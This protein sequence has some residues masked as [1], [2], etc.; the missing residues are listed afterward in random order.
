MVRGTTCRCRCGTDWLTTLFIATS[1]PYSCGYHTTNQPDGLYDLRAIV[2]DGAGR[3][4]TSSVVVDRRVDNTAP[5][6]ADVQTTNAGVTGRL[7]SGDS[8]SF[9]YSELMSTG[10]ISSGWDGSAVPVSLRLLDGRLVGPAGTSDTVDILRGGSAVNLGSVNLR[11][12][13]IGNN[14]TAQ[15]NATMVASTVTVNG[16]QVTRVTISV[17]TQASGSTVRTT[18][19]SST[20]SWTPSGLATDLGGLG[21]NTTATFESGTFDRQF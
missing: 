8:I 1:S 14:Q 16:V 21:T 11:E 13:Y 17:G 7:E 18:S 9:T 20:M 6:A 4:T 19:V 3:T 15:F 5:R 10:S 12:D 2:T